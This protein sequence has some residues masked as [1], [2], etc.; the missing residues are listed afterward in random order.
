MSRGTIYGC[1]GLGRW[2]GAPLDPGD[3][4][5]A[6]AAVAAALEIGIDTF[7]H[8]DIYGH[9]SA[10]AVFG[11]LLDRAPGLRDRIRIQSKCGIRLAAGD[12]P[13]LYDLRPATIRAQVHASLER[14]RTDHLDLVLLHRPDPLADPAEIGTALE[15]LHAEGVVRAIGV[16]NM[17]AAQVAALQ[18]HTALPIAANQ[19]EMS[20]HARG[21]VEAGV[22]VNTPAYADVGFPHGTL[23]HCTH[24]GIELQAWGSLAGGRFTGRALTAR[25]HEVAALVAD[26]AALHQTT[27]EAIVLTW[28][29][30]HPA[31]VVPV[32][33]T[34]DP[35]RIRACAPAVDRSRLLTH[36]KWYELWITA[37]GAPLP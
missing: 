20:L 31:A 25:D 3:H 33:G 23:E 12:R 6:E 36:E 13:G 7:D 32:I 2:D 5:R 11:A 9:G 8:A 16:S 19:L 26:L 1:M 14:L 15:A 21:W 28:L 34:T 24:H 10:E 18:A 35:D 4:A 30:Q 29:Q 17:S 37:R 22:L 27:A